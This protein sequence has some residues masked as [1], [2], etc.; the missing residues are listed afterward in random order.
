MALGWYMALFALLR[1]NDLLG[2]PFMPWF[3]LSTVA[4]AASVVFLCNILIGVIFGYPAS[5]VAAAIATVAAAAILGILFGYGVLVYEGM[6]LQFVP[7][8]P[9]ARASIAAVYLVL[10]VAM[11]A[12]AALIA[13]HQEPV[14]RRRSHLFGA[15]AMLVYLPNAIRYVVYVPEPWVLAFAPIMA[16]GGWVGWISARTV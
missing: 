12:T 4:G 7:V 1:F 6:D 13:R 14:L 10:P 2:L 15:A 5:R 8:S 9:L 3:Y 11:A 16:I